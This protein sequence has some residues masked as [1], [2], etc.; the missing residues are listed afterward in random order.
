MDTVDAKKAAEAAAKP[1]QVVIH[2]EKSDKNNIESHNRQDDEDTMGT[3][4]KGEILDRKSW[5]L[6][7]NEKRGKLSHRTGFNLKNKELQQGWKLRWKVR[8]WSGSFFKFEMSM[9]KR[10]I[11]TGLKS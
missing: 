8:C 4:M 5:S 3:E 10:I 11:E 1:D 2:E 7:K 9:P 6:R